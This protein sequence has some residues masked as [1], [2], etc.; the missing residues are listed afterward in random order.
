MKFDVPSLEGLDETQPDYVGQLE[1][2][3]EQ[4]GLLFGVLNEQFEQ[5]ASVDELVEQLEAEG[6]TVR[7]TPYT[8]ELK[9]GDQ[10]LERAIF[11]SVGYWFGEEASE[12]KRRKVDDIETS[13]LRKRTR[14]VEDWEDNQKMLERAEE[15]YTSAILELTEV[16]PLNERRQD[17][18]GFRLYIIW[19]DQVYEMGSFI[20]QDPKY[21]PL[22]ICH[23][24]TPDMFEDK[25]FL[26]TLT[27]KAEEEKLTYY[28]ATN[29][30]RC[31][32][33]KDL[34]FQSVIRAIEQGAVYAFGLARQAAAQAQEEDHQDRQ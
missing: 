12:A 22:E 30:V 23:E 4:I 8:S 20:G 11:H 34:R 26:T 18:E 25:D 19:D 3:M 14:A 1:A 32:S 33:L 31:V 17:Y 7:V 28:L 16:K 27:Q 2:G 10:L 15:D 24:F 29:P 5:L 9:S 6:L 13:Y 21:T